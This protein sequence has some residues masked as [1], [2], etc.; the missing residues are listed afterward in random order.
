MTRLMIVIVCAASV[1]LALVP[2]A[3]SAD[4]SWRGWTYSDQPPAN[5]QLGD[6]WL[7]TSRHGVYVVTAPVL[8][9][10]QGPSTKSRVLYKLRAGELVQAQ[11]DGDVD[12]VRLLDDGW[13]ASE[14]LISLPVHQNLRYWTGTHWE[15]VGGKWHKIA[16]R[17]D[18]YWP[19]GYTIIMTPEPGMPQVLGF[20][21]WQAMYDD[22]KSH[23]GVISD[24]GLW[25]GSKFGSQQ[26]SNFV[27]YPANGLTPS[28]HPFLNRQQEWM[29][30]VWGKHFLGTST[31]VLIRLQGDPPHTVP[32]M[33]IE[34]GAEDGKQRE[35]AIYVKI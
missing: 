35:F 14:H 21:S 31:Q 5:P 32:V 13:V 4:L 34:G 3:S 9:V 25:H 33:R 23:D 11:E 6:G 22:I 24:I 16:S 17:T 28:G 27:D 15:P 20:D 10:R 29:Y 30:F 1:F 7:P 26:S 8:N 19:D 18:V 2:G 12:W